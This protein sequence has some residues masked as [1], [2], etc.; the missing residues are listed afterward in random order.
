RRMPR[1]QRAPPRFRAPATAIRVIVRIA[2]ARAIRLS[3]RTI[4]KSQRVLAC[5]P[6][7]FGCTLAPQTREP[8]HA[9]PSRGDTSQPPR[10]GKPRSRRDARF[11]GIEGVLSRSPSARS[12]LIRFC[13][14][15][16]LSA[17]QLYRLHSVW[18]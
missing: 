5:P 11:H 15:R 7:F 12:A 16:A 9:R 14:Q 2:E 18:L 17:E 1:L 8:E 4:R 13:C 10:F 3:P 6:R